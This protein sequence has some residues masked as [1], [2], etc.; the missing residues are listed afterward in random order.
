MMRPSAHVDAGRLWER[1]LSLARHGA[2]VAGGVNRQ[3]LSGEEIAARRE[4]MTIAGA[5]GLAAFTDA[6]GNFFLRMEGR[7]ADAPPVL[8]G[9]HIDSQPTGGR[10]DGIYGVLAGIE[11]IEAL[12]ATGITPRRSI[13]VVSWMNEEGS[14][15]APGMMGSAAFA[16]A[17]ELGALLPI[18]D[19]EGNSVERELARMRDAFPDVP[20]RPLGRPIA[21]Y[22]EAHIEQG[23]VLEQEA[24]SVGVVTGIQGKRT[25]R[26]T[27]TGEEAHAGTA[28]LRMRKDALLAATAIIQGLSKAFADPDDILKFTVG[29]IEVQPNA[30]SVVAGQAVF[31]ID[32]R[33]PDSGRLRALGDAIAG[34]C[35]DHG[36]PCAV[37]VRELT[38]AMSLEFP[39]AIRDLIRSCA[40]DIGIRTLDLPSAAGH[41]ARFLH[42]I[43]PSGMIFVPCKGGISHNESE[44]AVASD[45]A[46]GARVLSDVLLALA[47]D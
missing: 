2:T 31:S 4:L 10:F 42:G 8:T 43:C 22:I 19:A 16:G 36:R 14:R 7:E 41:D 20:L 34:L 29:R 3:A 26:V 17:V 18:S 12:R 46:D 44:S 25:F 40:A 39:Q 1:H 38:S 32:L 47:T 11:A 23:P 15:F 35:A 27:V 33:H 5:L 9:S 45:L 13:E 28:A 21:A 6:A 30:P 37:A 24:C